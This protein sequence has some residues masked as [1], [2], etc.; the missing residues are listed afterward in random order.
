MTR[1]DMVP[2]KQTDG[3]QQQPPNCSFCGAASNDVEYIVVSS[4]DQT[5]I[6]AECIERSFELLALFRKDEA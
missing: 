4:N 6:C 2:L 5:A 3:L 1:D